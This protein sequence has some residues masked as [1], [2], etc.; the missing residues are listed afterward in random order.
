MAARIAV[1]A[2]IALAAVFLFLVL[3]ASPAQCK[4]VDYSYNL[5]WSL[6][7]MSITD[8]QIS[9]YL[10]DM[11]IS[12]VHGFDLQVVEGYL[13]LEVQR[14]GTQAYHLSMDLTLMPEMAMARSNGNRSFSIS[15]KGPVACVQALEPSVRFTDPRPEKD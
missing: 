14:G 5:C 4:C 13:R 7:C 6:I 15:T 8:S 12:S 3:S 2:P 10:C 11:R 1:S 9:T